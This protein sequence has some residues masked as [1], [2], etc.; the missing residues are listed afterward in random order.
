MNI[1]CKHNY[2]WTSF[3]GCTCPYCL[4]DQV[5][6][7][8]AEV[9]RLRGW[10]DAVISDYIHNRNQGQEEI[11]GGELNRRTYEQGYRDGNKETLISMQE[12]V[13]QALEGGQG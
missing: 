6:A 7:L 2:E 1:R 11:I 12:W 10:Q 3:E 13:K 5:Q 9:E 8:T 4:T